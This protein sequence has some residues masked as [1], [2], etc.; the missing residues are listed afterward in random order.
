MGAARP[1]RGRPG[2][3]TPGPRARRQPP[4]RPWRWGRLLVVSLALV[5]VA[6]LV[7]QALADTDGGGMPASGDRGVAPRS[8]AQVLHELLGVVSPVAGRWIVVLEDPRAPARTLAE[9]YRARHGARIDM[10]FGS[11][12]RGFAGRLGPAAR[13]RAEN[14]PRVA[15]VV[16]DT[17][18]KA[19][20]QALPP[21]IDRVDGERSVARSG[22]GRGAVDVDVAVI[23]TGID[24]RH[25]DLRVAGGTDCTGE[26]GITDGNG[27]GTHVAGTIAATDDG[28]GV[29][30]VAP[31]ARLWA[32]K[33]L[34]AEG[35][36]T[37]SSIICAV[38]W[39]AANADVIE[40]AN[41]SLGGRAVGEP[42][43]ACGRGDPLHDAVCRA[44]AAGVTIV[45]AA[46]NEAEDA[47]GYFPA[48]YDEVITVSALADYD[49]AQ[50]GVSPPSCRGGGPDDTRA[51]FSNYGRVVDVIAPGTCVLS[52]VPGGGVAR[53]S[54]TSMA[55]PHVAGAAALLAAGDPD[56]S[57]GQVKDALRHAGS[58]AWDDRD[59]PDGI[60]EPL[61]DTGALPGGTTQPP[62]TTSSTRESPG[63]ER[64]APPDQQQ[65][66]VRRVGR[67]AQRIAEDLFARV[68]AERRARGLAPLRRDP[69]LA[70]LAAQWSAEMAR[71]GE[72]EHR[73]D[74]R[75][76][77]TDGRIRVGGNIASTNGP[78][79]S[80]T[81]HG[82]WM[83]SDG[84]R[85]NI[86]QP[87]FDSMG[88]GVV[89]DGDRVYA[90]QLFASTSRAP[91]AG[92]R[93]PPRSPSAATG[94]NGLAG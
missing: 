27:H 76:A 75:R 2:P 44:V 31:G 90:T 28:G 77:L 60:Q 9:E 45:V 91:W 52:T 26:G 46:G 80:R 22:D 20:E 38:D 18:V 82:L 71:S 72:F 67:V 3:A 55:S 7:P 54:G 84:H 24:P 48:G 17:L 56:A 70:L 59:D 23:D 94:S 35:A 85:E 53:L 40:V 41:L 19:S 16:P 6:A 49:G 13:L 14:D 1:V 10:V 88:I 69:A 42:G 51:R 11:T 68:N 47:G 25:P 57:P 92:D 4:R 32:V 12:L 43:R 87:G 63:P 36:G 93:V 37:T 81:V 58:A 74:L 86:L 78:D 73:P 39:V 83:R 62:A 5:V 89:C 30:G 61:L 33:A 8:R 50:G 21:G 34:N 66:P 64:T 29:V 65:G 15:A 79:Q